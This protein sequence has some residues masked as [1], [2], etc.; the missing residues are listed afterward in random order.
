MLILL[1][2]LSASWWL[3]ERRVER[4][5][6]APSVVSLW[7]MG[8]MKRRDVTQV[9]WPWYPGESSDLDLWSFCRVAT[10]DS[11]VLLINSRFVNKMT[12]ESIE[13]LQINM[14]IQDFLPSPHSVLAGWVGLWLVDLVQQ[15][16]MFLKNNLKNTWVLSVSEA[17]SCG[18][19]PN[20]SVH[21]FDPYIVLSPLCGAC[22]R[23][24]VPLF[25][26]PSPTGMHSCMHALCLKNRL[27]KKKRVT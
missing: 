25:H 20:L 8:R 16:I 22:L 13:A 27:E 5:K 19:G 14:I 24:S 15:S 3:T 21:E 10:S 7:D 26:R 2:T 1:P 17:P 18:P 6:A 12:F 11:P 9:C 4:E 23:S